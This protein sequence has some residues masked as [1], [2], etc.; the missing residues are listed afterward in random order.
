MFNNILLF[1]ETIKGEPYTILLPIALILFLSKVLSILCRKF[2]LPQVVGFLLAGIVVGL[3]TFIPNQQIL[4]DYTKNGI[5]ELAKIG[6]VLIMFS[7]GLE[8]DTKKIKA[9]GIG[10]IIITVMGVIFP[11]IFGF[12][13]AFAFN[14]GTTLENIF[15]GVILSATS[16]S[17]TVATLKELGK[18][19]SKVGTSIVSAA[20]LDDIIGVI[21]LSFVISLNGSGSSSTDVLILVGKMILFFALAFGLGIFI[22]KAFIWLDKKYPHTRRIPIFGLA[23]CFFYAYAAEAWFGVA[24]ITGAFVAGLVLAGMSEETSYIDRKAEVGTYL[25]FGPIFFANIGLLMFNDMNFDNVNFIW[26]G[27]LFILAGI[28]GK[29]I[30][31]G[32]GAKISKFNFSDSLK[33]GIGMMARA[34]VVIVCAQKGINS[35]MVK[36]EIMP[37]ILILIIIT[38]FLTPLL[39]KVVYSKQDK[40]LSP[41]AQ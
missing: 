30:G 3:I 19:D 6:V 24:D 5:E 26:F 18:L 35:G 23:L 25:I 8:T 15:Y 28:I 37:F 22:K 7:A 27:L 33:I 11:L 32:L 9:C 41:N 20:I 38:T 16:V 1:T 29:I 2:H 34:E 36:P 21:L 31:C 13:A 17:I 14:I 40:E 12:L 39:L 4:T 10:S